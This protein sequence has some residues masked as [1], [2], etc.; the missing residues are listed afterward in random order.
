MAKRSWPGVLF[1]LDGT[2]ADTVGLIV[3]SY[4]HAL[5]TVVGRTR[6]A[7]EIRSWIGR[8]LLETFE[9]LD[10]VHAVELDRVYREWNLAHTARLVQRYAGVPELLDRLGAAGVAVGV[11]TSKRREAAA[12]VLGAVGLDGRAALVGTLEDTTAHKPRP[13]PLLHGASALGLDPAACV[14]VGDAVVDV[15]A[16]RAAG[17]ASVAVTWGAGRADALRA[18]DPTHLVDTV[19]AL[20]TLLL[21]PAT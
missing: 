21:G 3:A 10:P 4:H 20:G 17:M 13:D 19:A 14:Y 11:V 12:A 2:L 5:S 15:L 9:E 7:E 6:D 1:D 18:A 8:P 16:A